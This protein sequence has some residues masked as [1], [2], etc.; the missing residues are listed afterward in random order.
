MIIL[1]IWDRKTYWQIGIFSLMN[2]RTSKNALKFCQKSDDHINENLLTD[3]KISDDIYSTFSSLF[4]SLASLPTQ[5]F[6]L[7]YHQFYPISQIIYFLS[8]LKTCNSI[9]LLVLCIQLQLW[10]WYI[11]V[12]LNLPRF[13]TKGFS[14]Q[15]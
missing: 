12:K 15:L 3:R 14:T 4:Q 11:L 7:T 2:L 1:Q 9:Q 5:S 10:F 6:A 13:G 8:I